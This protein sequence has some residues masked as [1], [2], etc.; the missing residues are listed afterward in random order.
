[1]RTNVNEILTKKLLNIFIKKGKKN[2]AIKIY[3][4][5]LFKVQLKTGKNAYDVILNALNNIKPIVDVRDF[6]KGRSVFQMPYLLND[7]QGYK[8]ALKWLS[9]VSKE[10]KKNKM[11]DN[12]VNELILAYEGKGSCIKKKKELY[13]LVSQNR[14]NIYMQKKKY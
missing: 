2:K 14:H 13:K 7:Y 3:S 10:N 5:M 12:F 4:Y 11:V 1:M 9:I 8:K 6:K